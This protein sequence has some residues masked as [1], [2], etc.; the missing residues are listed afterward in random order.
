[1]KN[2]TYYLSLARGLVGYYVKFKAPNEDV[3]RN[4]AAKYFGRLW[5]SV[6]QDIAFAGV[7]ERA[8]RRGDSCIVIN[9]NKPILLTGEEGEWE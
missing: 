5:C 4:H 9:D 7:L 6:Y 1:M 8:A 2:N 3:V